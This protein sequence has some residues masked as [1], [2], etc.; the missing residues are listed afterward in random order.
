[1]ILEKWKKHQKTEFDYQNISTIGLCRCSVFTLHIVCTQRTAQSKINNIYSARFRYH[2]SF[3]GG[4]IAT[5]PYGY[6]QIGWEKLYIFVYASF[7]WKQQQKPYR[8]VRKNRIG[9]F[10]TINEKK[11][12]KKKQRAESVT[13]CAEWRFLDLHVV[14]LLIDRIFDGIVV[15]WMCWKFHE[16]RMG[17]DSLFHELAFELCFVSFSAQFFFYLLCVC[18]SFYRFVLW[19]HI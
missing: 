4:A 9:C 11:K 18:K 15:R 14:R 16:V 2:S 5:Q 10:F 7:Y 8:S 1:M 6:H 13:I 3:G 12:K 17:K 19:K